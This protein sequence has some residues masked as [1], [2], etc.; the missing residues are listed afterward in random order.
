MSAKDRLLHVL[1]GRDFAQA[2]LI[3]YAVAGLAFSVAMVAP[4]DYAC[5]EYDPCPGCGFRTAM[6][7]ACRLEF[8]AAFESSVLLVPVLGVLLVAVVDVTAM[9][10]FSVRRKR[11]RSVLCGTS[12]ERVPA[13]KKRVPA[14]SEAMS[15]SDEG[16]TNPTTQRRHEWVGRKSMR[17]KTTMER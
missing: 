3:A 1:Y 17:P 6:V 15:E 10:V 16:A 11:N 14:D 2:R 12:A 4:L 8:A 5:S 13:P 9:A 7:Y